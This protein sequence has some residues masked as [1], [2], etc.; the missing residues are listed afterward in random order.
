LPKL[1][2]EIVP[3]LKSMD[4]AAFYDADNQQLFGGYNLPRGEIDKAWHLSD[5]ASDGRMAVFWSVAIG[6]APP[7]VWEKLNR[8]TEEHY[9]LTIFRP[10]WMGGGLF[11]QFQH[12]LFLDEW[13][14]PIGR[15][16][17]DFAYAQMIYAE[18]LGLPVWGWSACW[19]PDD[20]YLGWG[21]LEV[22]VVTPHA[23]GMAA[24]VYPHKAAECLRKLEG[25]GVREPFTEDG[26]TYRFGFRDSIN[27]DTKAVCKRYV[28]PLDQA[29]MF[30]ALANA[31]DDGLVQKLFESHPTVQRGRKIIAEYAQ[32]V[33]ASRLAELHRRDREPLPKTAA[34]KSSGPNKV[35]IADFESAEV[36]WD[37]LGGQIT[38]WLRD[39]NDSTVNFKL[40]RVEL[41]RDGRKIGCLRIDYDVESPNAAFG[42]VNLALEHANGAGCSTLELWVRGEPSAVKLELHGK[43]GIGSTYLRGIRSDAWTQFKIPYPKL[44]GLI[45]DWSDLERIVFVIEDGT[46]QPKTGS[47]MLDEIRLVP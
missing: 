43:G 26:K 12:G 15:S 3:L 23:P 6:A 4:W 25:M 37:T 1:H 47:L 17:A 18:Q 7:A 32:P 35:L 13:S 36:T 38:T 2:E 28:G 29:M 46:A 41:D 8:P 31:L 16:A 19:A 5:Y 20:R 22:P 24:M 39:A 11:M 27:L 34:G 30:L 10:A 45:T 44:G 33:D 14:T 9:G 40:S 42:G 21:T